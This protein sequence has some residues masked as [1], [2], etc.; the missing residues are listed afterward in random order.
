MANSKTLAY[1]EM[2]QTPA[3]SSAMTDSRREFGML[4]FR[5]TN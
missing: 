1:M 4:H 3:T 5:L 2:V